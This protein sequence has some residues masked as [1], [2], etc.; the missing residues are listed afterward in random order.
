M[1]EGREKFFP[2]QSGRY[3]NRFV[4]VNPELNIKWCPLWFRGKPEKAILNLFPSFRLFRSTS[5]FS[6]RVGLSAAPRSLGP[7]VAA[8]FSRAGPAFTTPQAV[9]AAGRHKFRG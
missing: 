9:G 3:V 8:V 6:E 2:G 7:V 4:R 5:D 1:L